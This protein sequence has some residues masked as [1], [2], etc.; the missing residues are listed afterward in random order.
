[1]RPSQ[2]L[3]AVLAISHT[4][5]ALSEAFDNFH[6]LGDVKHM[7]VGRQNDNS[8][9]NNNNNNNN[10]ND[11][12]SDT[13]QSAQPTS[14]SPAQTSENNNDNQASETPQ[15]SG[16]ARI[17]GSAGSRT[18]SGKPKPTSYDPRKAAGGVTMLKP[19]IMQGEVF[20]K[21]GDWVTFSWN[22]T[23]LS[24]TPTAL[25]ILASCTA[26]QAMYT[27][28]VNH[29]ADSTEVLWNTGE[30]QANQPLFLN[31]KYT[32]IM[33]DSDSSI[34]AVPQAGYLGVFKGLSFGMYTP[35]DYK[36][37][38]EGFQCANCN[39]ALSNFERMTLKAMLFTTGTTIGSLLYFTYQF[40]LW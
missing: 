38:D 35:Q 18:T 37:L 16:S 20:Y 2:L 1:M 12:A 34:S 13:P 5:V 19:D 7:F 36:D 29:S 9:N 14:D 3:A 27:I 32:L 23:S 33:Y 24:S 39:S 31:S 17:S 4:T 40:G 22:Y 25:D 6:G 21:V 26:N 30:K 28:A 15:G 11:A 8:D 10:N